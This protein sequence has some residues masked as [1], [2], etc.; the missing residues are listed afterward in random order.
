MSCGSAAPDDQLAA[1]HDL[2]FVHED[3][4]LLGHQ[5]FVDLTFRIGDLQPHLALRLLAEGNRAGLLGERALVL[6]R[7]RLEQFGHARQAAG[8]VARLLAFDRNARKHLA[9]GEIL[10][11]ADLDQCADRERDRHRVIGAGDLHLVAG[12]VEKLDL[13]SH[14]LGRSAALRIDHDECRQARHFVDLLRDGDAFLDVLE[15]RSSGELGDDRSRQRVPV[16][17]HGARLDRL[18][19]LDVERRSVRQLVTLALAAVLVRDDDLAGS[20]DHD[21]LALAVGHV[22]HRRVEPR[23]AVGLRVDARR[24]GRA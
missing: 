4:L 19:G 3:V 17:Q 20:R 16:G 7:T 2:A 8:D 22:A 15:L 5:L 6:R 1:V 14:N 18:V 12:L 21:Q 11:V 23:D 24:D 10:A 9:R 13:R